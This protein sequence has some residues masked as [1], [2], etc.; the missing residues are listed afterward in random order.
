MAVKWIKRIL[1]LV[2]LAGI[3]GGFTWLMWPQPIQVDVAKAV[4][5]HMQL[6]ADEDGISRIRKVYTVSAPVAGKLE[7]SP[8][9]V[10]DHVVAG[11]TTVAAIRSAD[12]TMLDARTRL[13]LIAAVEAAKAD[14]DFASAAVLQAEKEYQ[15]SEAELGRARYLVGKKVMALNALEKRQLDTDSAQQRLESAKAQLDVRLHNLEIAETR[16][17]G[18]VIP[19]EAAT[20]VECC[21]KLTSPVNGI[22]LHILVENEQIVQAGTPLVEVGNPLDTEIVVDLLS[23]DAMMVKPGTTAFISG[24]GGSNDLKARV[25][26]VEPAAFTKISAL[27][28]EEQ[29]VKA[30]LEISDPPSQWMGLG[31]QYRVFVRITIWQSDNAL[32]VPLSALFRRDGSWAVFKVDGGIAKVTRITA[33]QMTSSDA[34]I[35]SGLRE[36]ETVIVHPSDLIADG[37]RIEI[38]DSAKD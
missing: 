25:K 38:R 7:R 31:H 15:F 8:R 24:W 26:R 9:E 29:R 22:I 23:T 10:G 1:L 6:T 16:L 3:A 4:L 30:I 17:R 37:V 12:P 13:E 36:G 14:R 20:S 5:G 35:L 27:G 21:M 33:G 19:G 28:I 2:A 18:P 32:Q 11:V 34:Q